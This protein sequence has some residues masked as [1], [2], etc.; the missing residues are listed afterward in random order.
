MV[1][2]LPLRTQVAAGNCSLGPVLLGFPPICQLQV[3]LPRWVGRLPA[4]LTQLVMSPYRQRQVAPEVAD[5]RTLDAAIFFRSLP[6][7]RSLRHLVR[8]LSHIMSWSTCISCTCT[9][10]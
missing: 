9:N 5:G 7:L 1:G 10:V 3:T 6:L 4:G 2:R 8:F